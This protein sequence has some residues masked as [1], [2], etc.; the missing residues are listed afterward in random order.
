MKFAF[1]ERHKKSQ[2]GLDGRGVLVQFM[3]V[4]RIANFRAQRVARA[5][6]AGLDAERLADGENFVPNLPDGLVG[7]DDF[8]S[9]LA[10]V[11]GARDEDAVVFKI[12]P[13][14]LVFLQIGHAR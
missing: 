2:P 1:V 3:A 6:A 8:K 12:E 4:K 7:A 11:A 9:I 13:A 10:G 5:E 14:D